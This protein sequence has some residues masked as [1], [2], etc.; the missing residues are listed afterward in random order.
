MAAAQA[1]VLLL[2]AYG[3]AGLLFGIA[4]VTRGIAQVDQVAEDAPLGFRLIVLPGSAALWPLLLVRWIRA[5]RQGGR[6]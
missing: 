3:A 1:F 4:F 6:L 5:S 2:A